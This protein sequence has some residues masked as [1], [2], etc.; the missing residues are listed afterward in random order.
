[1]SVR[2]PDG[3]QSYLRVAAQHVQMLRVEP[4][5]LNNLFSAST[6][7]PMLLPSYPRRHEP[8]Y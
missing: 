4:F 2:R 3:F 1:M 7:R 8:C 5:N 6:S